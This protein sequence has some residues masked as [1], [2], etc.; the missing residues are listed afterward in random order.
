M[1]RRIINNSEDDGD[2]LPVLHR[3]PPSPL[4]S[5]CARCLTC[6]QVRLWCER[7]VMPI[8]QIWMV[9]LPGV[10]VG[11]GLSPDQTPGAVL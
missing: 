2:G 11:A 9:R 8:L 4:P 5:F 10:S 7:T 3:T 6:T 1:Q